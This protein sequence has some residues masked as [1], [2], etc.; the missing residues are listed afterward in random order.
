MYWTGLLLALLPAAL[1]WWWTRSVFQPS[2]AAVLPERHLAT[3][4][5]VSWVSMMCSVAIIVGARWHATWILPVQFVALT[6]TT[7]RMRRAIFGE[8]WPFRSYLSW[9][10][11]LH[12][13]MFGLWWFVA[14][15]PVVVAQASPG[16]AWWLSGI[17]VTIALAWHHWNGRVLLVLLRASRLERPDLDGH[18]QRV[19]ASARVPTPDLWRAGEA[20]GR[21]ANAFAL[22]T[23]SQR[24]VL[25][26][27]SMLDQLPADEVTAILAHEVEHLEQFHHRRL[28]AMNSVNKV[29]ILHMLVGT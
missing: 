7:Y 18:F 19:F 21:L 11:R 20:G 25:F 4:Q 16:A 28:L 2:A 14:L 1:H 26:F 13:G 3:A 12:V 29:L 9:R 27:D 15:A 24:G 8:T 6:A 5:R 22:V 17:A 10:L 23:L